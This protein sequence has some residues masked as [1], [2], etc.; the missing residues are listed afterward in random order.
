M[1][2][3]AVGALAELGG[4]VA[5]FAT[6]IYLAIQVKEN[7]VQVRLGSAIGLN[8]LINEA[9]D[10]IYNNDRNIHIWTTGIS[11]PKALNEQDIAVFSLFM[12]RLVNVLL[13]ALM[14]NDYEILDTEVAR[15]YLGS[16]KSIL[17]SPGGHYWLNELEGESQLSGQ[18]LGFL[19]KVIDRQEFLVTSSRR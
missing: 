8:H 6:L 18:M 9:F 3:D 5:V 1:D 13:T 16:L 19:D 17:E 7:S 15:R 14:H 4:A 12:A 10:P 2:W 11:D